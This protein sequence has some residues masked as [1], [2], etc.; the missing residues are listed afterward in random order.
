MKIKNKRNWKNHIAHGIGDEFAEA[1]LILRL[2]ASVNTAKW[3]QN[4]ASAVLSSD[5]IGDLREK[6][7]DFTYSLFTLHFYL[8]THSRFWKVISKSE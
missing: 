1:C 4:S 2:I 3:N 6:V 5:K 7:A 8:K